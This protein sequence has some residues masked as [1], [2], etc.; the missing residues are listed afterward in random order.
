MKYLGDFPVG[1]RVSDLWNTQA[2]DGASITRSTDGSLRVYKANATIGT[3]Q[4]QRSSSAGIT[5]QEDF[6]SMTGVHAYTIDLSDDTDAGFY[7]AGGEYQVVYQ[8]MTIDGM[9]VNAVIASF[10]IERAGGA[11]AMLKDA[12][13]G[14]SALEALVDDLESRLTSTRAGY[15]DKLQ[16]LPSATAGASGGLLI[17][18]S[19]SGTTTFGALTCTGALTLGSLTNNGTTTLTG[20]VTLSAGMKMTASTPDGWTFEIENTAASGTG[21]TVGLF[22]IGSGSGGSLYGYTNYGPTVN[23]VSLSGTA[24]EVGNATLGTV[25]MNVTGNI[26]GNLSGS[27][28]SVTGAVG[29]V[30]GNVGGNVA[31]SVGSVTGAVGSVTGN[32]GGNVAG[33]VGSV[34]GLTASDVAAIKGVTEKL[35]DTLEDDGGTYRFTANAL[36]EA[37]TGGSAPSAADIADAVWDEAISGHLTSGSTGAALNAAGSAGD[38]WSTPLPGAYGAGTAGYIVGTNVDAAIS[39][40]STYAGADTAGTTTLLSRLTSTRAGYLDNLTNL[41]ATITSRLAGASYTAPLDAAGTRTALGLASAN[42]DTQLGTLATAADL[43]TVDGIADAIKLKTDLIPAGGF[44]SN[45]HVLAITGGGAVTAG[46]VSDKAGYALTS[47]YD[48][49]KTAAQAGD[50]M[51]LTSGERLA[52]HGAVATTQ[53][54]ESYRANGAAPTLAQAVCELLAHHGEAANVGDE[55]T[56]RR[57]DHST[58]AMVFEYDDGT[59]PTSVTR[60]S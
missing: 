32:V 56:L 53:L 46:T 19:N 36:E 7:A 34:T 17:S 30:T 51:T 23:L 28:G 60:T 13:Y 59:A 58:S 16:Y 6:D 18:G 9:S 41:D 37:P 26:T 49:A 15:L 31:G 40:R 25:T 4:T 45:F 2:A 10:S 47:D 22:N 33:S 14:L 35:D 52:V 1:G 42:L 11:L 3:W 12:T 39:S 50:A 20:R 57:F 55:K 5:E 27:V 24:L 44:P 21:G 38:P 43:A 29:S 48:P 8:G 54:T